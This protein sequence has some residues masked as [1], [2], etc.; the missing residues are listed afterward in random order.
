MRARNSKSGTNNA[1]AS[2]SLSNHEI[3]TLAVYLMGGDRGHIDTEDV[4]VKANELAPGRFVWKKY[5][6][7]IN[8]KNV[9]AFLF[10]ARKEKYGAY[11]IGSGIEGW[12]LTEAGLAFAKQAAS[13]LENLDLSKTRLSS[14]ER[15]WM[16]RERERMLAD[17]VMDQLDSGESNTLT[18]GDALRF[19]K[20]DPY[21]DNRS[22][23]ARI[24]RYLNYL[25][26]DPQ[27]GP[28]I[29]TLLEVLEKGDEHDQS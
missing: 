24:Q 17:P 11:V 27:L 15:Q 9:E 3:V 26:E 28:V 29:R 8:I 7:Q 10:D 18:K 19:F 21:L 23:K 2:E 14:K 6:E 1:T 4:A 5:N 12:L 25:G 16:M 13:K 22:R 20:V